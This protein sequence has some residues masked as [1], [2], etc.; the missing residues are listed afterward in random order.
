MKKIP[1]LMYFGEWGGRRID[2]IGKGVINEFHPI[3]G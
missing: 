2:W 3:I 1:I